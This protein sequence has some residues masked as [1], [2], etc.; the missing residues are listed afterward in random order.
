MAFWKYATKIHRV[1]ARGVVHTPQFNGKQE[2]LP[3]WANLT[4]AAPATVR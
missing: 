4:C 1:G 3:P 2:G